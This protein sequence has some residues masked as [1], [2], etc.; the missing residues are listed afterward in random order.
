MKRRG[1][2]GAAAEYMLGPLGVA[3][4]GLSRTRG[5]VAWT[6]PGGC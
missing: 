2:A 1:R 4:A 3:A 5:V 6:G